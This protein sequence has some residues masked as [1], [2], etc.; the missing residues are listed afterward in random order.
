MYGGGSSWASG[1]FWGLSGGA[2][3]GSPFGVGRS[4]RRT[5]GTAICGGGAGWAYEQEYEGSFS[6]NYS[7]FRQQRN[8]FPGEGSHHYPQ[9]L[10][11][12]NGQAYS[13]PTNQMNPAKGGHGLTSKGGLS[14]SSAGWTHSNDGNYNFGKS[15]H[16]NKMHGD[17]KEWWFPWEVDGGGGGAGIPTDNDSW[18][19]G[20]FEGGTGGSG[21]GG[22]GVISGMYQACLTVCGGKGGFGGG[23]GSAGY[24]RDTYAG[25]P[26]ITKGGNG[27]IGGGGGAAWTHKDYSSSSYS[28]DNNYTAFGGHG[29][30]GCVCVYW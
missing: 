14:Y 6:L 4:P 28:S 19:D 16:V 24:G 30:N 5:G 11:S 23:G 2:S 12:W 15:L 13:Q 25:E 20:F 22:G 27:G 9:A 26:G 8:C 17:D 7:K 10:G 1:M 21:A 29:G 18:K 3:S